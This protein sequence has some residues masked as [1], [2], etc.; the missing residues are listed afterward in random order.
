MKWRASRRQVFESLAFG[1]VLDIRVDEPLPI[2]D[3]MF[4]SL[5]REKRLRAADRAGDGF[6]VL[7][8]D[9]RPARRL[10]L[11]ALAFRKA[12]RLRLPDHWLLGVV[13]ALPASNFQSELRKAAKSA[14][15]CLVNPI[16]NR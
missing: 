13:D 4:L 16:P 6:A 10:L 15:C 8:R 14:V 11:A 12:R 9:L 1:A 7:D 3:D 2:C 5:L